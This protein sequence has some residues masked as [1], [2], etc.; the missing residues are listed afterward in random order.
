MSSEQTDLP[1]LTETLGEPGSGFLRTLLGTEETEVAKGIA[2][3][4]DVIAVPIFAK[5]TDLRYTFVNAAFLDMMGLTKEAVLHHTAGDLVPD[6]EA[7]H[8]R[9]RDS[10]LIQRGGMQ[11][12]EAAVTSAGGYQRDFIFNKA[13]ISDDDGT[14]LGIVGVMLDVTDKN[15]LREEL[16][17][18]NHEIRERMKELNCLYEVSSLLGRSSGSVEAVLDEILPSLQKAMLHPGAA[19]VRISWNGLVRQTADFRV[20]GPTLSATIPSEMGLPGLIEVAYATPQTEVDKGPFQKEEQIL[21]TEIARILG[22]WIDGEMDDRAAQLSETRYRAMFDQSTIAMCHMNVDGQLLRVNDRAC[23][24]WCRDRET[25]LTMQ[26]SD[27]VVSYGEEY[28]GA[29]LQSLKEGS[30]ASFSQ[31]TEYETGD[32]ARVWGRLTLS[33][34]RESE[35]DIAYYVAMIEETTVEHDLRLRE[36]DLSHQVQRALRSTVRALSNAQE[37]RDP[38]TAG[39]QQRV[40]RLSVAIG[41]RLGLDETRLRALEMGALVHDIGKL[42]IP[43]DLLAKPGKLLPAEFELIK[44]HAE[45]GSEILSDADIP[46]VILDVVRHHHERLDGSGYPD[47]L[48]GDELSVEVRIIGIADTVEAVTSHRPYRPARGLEH[49]R[50]VLREGRGTAFDPKITDI[51]LALLDERALPW[52]QNVPERAVGEAPAAD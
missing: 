28:E 45:A 36:K 1:D 4:L 8:F 52:L 24:F 15:R 26:H 44:T 6:Q 49:A 48:T 7:T 12:Y 10:E 42:R 17:R 32:G 41:E 51:C 11:R 39:H 34:L 23:G 40:A 25:L 5:G 33:P 29:L 14:R 3:L 43:A 18:R 27:L 46:G 47:G 50:Q 35:N 37:S 16:D 9:E 2:T 19:R 30:I 20:A 13:V 22:L 38:Y 21:L 31:E